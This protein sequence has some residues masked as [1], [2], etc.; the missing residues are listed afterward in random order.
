M[1]IEVCLNRIE[2]NRASR[3]IDRSPTI[4]VRLNAGE[5]SQTSEEGEQIDE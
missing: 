5:C 4:L 2:P 3:L 1:N